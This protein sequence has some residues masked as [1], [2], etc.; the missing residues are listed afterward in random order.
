MRD[1]PICSRLPSAATNLGA[2]PRALHCWIERVWARSPWS[3]PSTPQRRRSASRSSWQRCIA[4]L[5]V[6]AADRVHR[7]VCHIAWRGDLAGVSKILSDGS[8]RARP[9]HRPRD[10]PDNNAL[11]AGAFPVIA[12][13]SES[14]PSALFASMMI[15]KFIDAF[16]LGPDHSA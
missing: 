9:S 4:R 15:P 1:R 16:F 8:P 2:T 10:A 5:A 12:A 3:A 7:V 6:A 14:E 13:H 11:V